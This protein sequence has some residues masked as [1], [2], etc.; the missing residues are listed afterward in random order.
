MVLPGLFQPGLSQL[1]LSRLH[2]TRLCGAEYSG[3]RLRWVFIFLWLL[4]YSFH[5]AAENRVIDDIVQRSQQQKLAQH[6]TW[7]ALLHYKDEVFSTRFVSQAD[8]AAFFLSKNGGSSPGD[9]LD[10]NLREMLTEAS[11]GHAQCRF[12]ARWFWLKQQ[13]DISAEYDVRCPKFESWMQQL[14]S[15]RLSLI[16]PS[17]YLNNPGSSFGHTFLRFDSADSPLLSHA[18]NYAASNDPDDHPVNYVYKGLFGG[19]TGV[20][21]TRRYFETVQV[22]SDIENRDI[23]EYRLTYTPAQIRQLVRH[24]WELEGIDFDYFFFRENCSY[25]LMAMLDVITEDASLSDTENFPF[26][27]IPVDTVRVLDNR[28]LIAERKYRPSLATRVAAGFNQLDGADRKIVLKL[29][30]SKQAID[31]LLA[32]VDSELRQAEMLQLGYRLMQFRQQEM[33]ERATQLMQRRSQLDVNYQAL[34]VTPL[35]PEKGHASARVSIGVGR[36]N[37]QSFSEITLRQAFHDLLDKSDGYIAGAEINVLD[38]AVRWVPETETLRL[39][40]FRFANLFSLTPVR[41]WTMPLSWQLDIKLENTKF[42]SI[43]SGLSFITRA[44]VGLSGEY[45]GTLFYGMAMLEADL[46]DE[47]HKGY[48]LLAGAQFGLVMPLPQAQLQFS[49]EIDEAI[50]GEEIKRHASEL[51]VQ[52]NLSS[53]LSLRLGYRKHRYEHHRD[54]QSVMRLQKF[55]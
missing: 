35:S 43:E 28:G 18:L 50:A 3:I 49:H 16:F 31:D 51:A 30:E 14:E 10:A 27:A 46:A 41:D 42:N 26:Y 7:L 25:R 19:Y 5:A 44:G 48:S 20:F 47:Y 29:V 13:L 33:S 36:H 53:S 55:F 38:V 8:D 32:N 52:F 22:Y 4:M 2:F 15:D 34:I 23:W 9:E 21:A 39:Q 12:P 6:P 40:K 17:M 45:Q 54:E 37:N 24:A 1:G 11:T